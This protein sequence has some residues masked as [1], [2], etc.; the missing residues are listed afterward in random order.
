[1]TDPRP[2]RE[3]GPV[4]GV[5]I[6]LRTPHLDEL[7]DDPS[8]VPWVEL[9]ADNHFSS[10][11]LTAAQL[12]AVA[13]RYRVTLHCVGMN[14]GGIDPLDFEYLK[15]VRDL[16][17][18]TQCA[19][20]SDHLCFTQYANRH[21]HDLLPL[22]YCENTLRHVAK[23]IEQV[24][25]YLGEPIL[26]ENVSAYLLA[27]A[28]M[29]EAEFLAELVAE[30][31]CGILL[32]INNLYVNEVNLGFD[33]HEALARIPLDQV[34]EIHI[35][36][37]EDRGHFVVDSHSTRVSEPVWALLETVVARNPEIPILVEWDN[38]IPSLDT[39]LSEAARA[40]HIVVK[41]PKVRTA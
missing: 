2:A 37:F 29:T 17:R 25:D 27:Q 19:W 23:R 41:V 40:N 8:L 32:D 22:P 11:G 28:P 12:S 14:I 7:L 26:I 1:M 6:G 39:L 20:V 35:A 18:R 3:R 4:Q 38:D 5:G 30:V 36:G 34:R 16:A 15:Q 31:E 13:E 10:G 33:A 24:Q 21:F 9:L